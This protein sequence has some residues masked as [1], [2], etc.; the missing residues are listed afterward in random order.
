MSIRMNIIAQ[1]Q[2]G[3]F[4]ILTPHPVAFLKAGSIF[5]PYSIFTIFKCNDINLAMTNHCK[6]EE[7]IL[8]SPLET[9]GSFTSLNRADNSLTSSF[10][11]EIL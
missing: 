4:L 9:L 1:N 5:K 2:L 7:D 10:S 3:Y 6:L 11:L 8:T